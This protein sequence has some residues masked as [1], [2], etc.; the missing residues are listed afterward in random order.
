[1]LPAPRCELPASAFVPREPPSS[2][3]TITVYV[4][5]SSSYASIYAFCAVSGD[6]LGRATRHAPERFGGL[7]TRFLLGSCHGDFSKLPRSFLGTRCRSG[8]GRSYSG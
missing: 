3:R 6:Y 7:R 4:A 5:T 1:M 2:T 8:R